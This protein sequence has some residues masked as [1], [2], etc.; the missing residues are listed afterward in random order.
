MSNYKKG[1]LVQVFD[2]S[3]TLTLEDNEFRHARGLELTDREFEVLNTD[4]KLP[5]VDEGE[6]NTT[7]LK[8]KDNNQIVYIQE[9]MIKPCA[10]KEPIVI[11][12]TI[13]ACDNFNAEQ[14]TKQ[15]E[16]EFKKIG[17]A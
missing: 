5:S 11:N 7:I 12:V 6:F 8:A 16:N 2:G 15:I 4:L 3:Y 13:N 14:F 17:L 10:K 1:D 9:Q